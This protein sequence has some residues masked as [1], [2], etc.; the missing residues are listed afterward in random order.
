MPEV[1]ESHSPQRHHPYE[2]AGFSIMG[3][4]ISTLAGWV[5]EGWRV[6]YQGEVCIDGVELP[7]DTWWG[8]AIRYFGG[9]LVANSSF[10][11]ATVETA[12]GFGFPAGDSDERVRALAGA[13]G[14]LPDA[15]IVLM[16][17]N[18]YGWGGARNQTMGRSA[19]ASARPEDLAGPREVTA[20][21][22]VDAL[23]RFQRAY[24]GM[25]ARIRGLAPAADI[26]C[27]TLAPGSASPSANVGAA[28]PVNPAK[29]INPA[30]QGLSESSGSQD[31]S[32]PAASETCWKYRLRGIDL[33]DYNH[34]IREE[35]AS[36]GARIADIRA[37]G[38]DYDAVDGVHPSVR[39]MEQLAAMIVAQM[40]GRPADPRRAARAAR[41]PAVDPP[42]LPRWLRGLRAR[43]SR[44]R[45]LDAPLRGPGAGR[46]K[47][48]SGLQ[49]L[50]AF[51][52]S[53]PSGTLASRAS[54]AFKRPEPPNALNLQTPRPPQTQHPG[55]QALRTASASDR[56]PPPHP[57]AAVRLQIILWG[58]FQVSV[59]MKGRCYNGRSFTCRRFCSQG[60]VRADRSRTRL[61]AGRKGGGMPRRRARPDA[62]PPARSGGDAW[63]HAR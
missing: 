43:R 19:A 40:E 23:A 48:A 29:P 30:A 47:V 2:G 8:R 32:V 42:L 22:D 57:R 54:R 35:A 60:S 12:E 41:C 28:E 33:D 13:D 5:P 58:L 16:G 53:G 4:S 20:T 18:D 62:V 7:E 24:A 25:L 61:L 26:W 46:S 56:P 3:D 9:R 38:V 31:A 14:E 50:W 44:S 6:H 21:A 17:I 45:P 63:L 36:A 15:V 27:A 59:Q 55:S 10:S 1:D 51:K 49:A 34:V 39:G 52:R 11:G 37:F